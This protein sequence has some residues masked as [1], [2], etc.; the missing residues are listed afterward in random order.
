MFLAKKNVFVFEDVVQIGYTII[1]DRDT[2][3]LEEVKASVAT[4]ARF[5]SQSYIYEEKRCQELGRP[6]RIWEDYSDYLHEP[7]TVSWRN[8]GMNAAI[9]FLKVHSKYKDCPNF[10]QNVESTVQKLFNESLCLMKPHSIYRN[11]VVH[12]D[13]WKNNILFQKDANGVLSSLFVDFQTVIYCSPMLDFSSFLYFNTR[14]NFR[15]YHLDG[16]LDL[17]HK[18]MS[19]ELKASNIEVTNIMNRET[20]TNC[21]KDSLTFAMVQSA[22]IVPIFL[23]NKET[24]KI[25]FESAESVNKFYE[26]SR[27]ENFLE[28]A[29]TDKHY[30]NHVLELLDEIV[31]RYIC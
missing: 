21:Y 22:L 27:S 25:I 19:K 15:E 16:L 6:Y 5:H 20:L 12:R 3:T 10:S 30:Q 18:V 23:I 28:L 4:M 13:L 31:E 8:V 29:K 1:R 24:T 14:R 26:I 9:D 17:Y 11:V 7:D 2:L